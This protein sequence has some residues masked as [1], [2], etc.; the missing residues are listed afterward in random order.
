MK[1]YLVLTYIF[2]YSLTSQAQD[3]FPALPIDSTEV[4]K[5]I[6]HL[7]FAQA[8]TLLKKE[9]TFA[10]RQKKST[11]NLEQQQKN[12]TFAK[13]ALRNTDK[14]VI[15]DSVVVPKSEL[16]SAYLFSPEVGS[17]EMENGGKTTSYTTERKNRTIKVGL[18]PDSILTLQMLYNDV[19]NSNAARPQN[20]KGLNISGDV[21]YPFLMMDGI[22]LY[23]A[24]IN[25]EG[26][27]NYDLYVTR[28][29]SET[30]TF[31]PAEN[32]GFPY[33]SYA[34]DYLLV[35]DEINNIGWF[36]SDRYQPSGYVCIYTFI[37]NASRHPVD[38]ENTAPAT[39]HQWATLLPIRSTWTAENEAQRI[40][41]R[42]HLSLQSV[43]NSQAKKREFELVI[44]DIY[45]YTNLSDFRNP[46]AKEL[47][48]EWI[49]K[50]K[51]FD[52]LSYQ[53]ET[54]RTTFANSNRT[55]QNNMRQQ[56][57][58]LEK[59]VEQINLEIS[60]AEKKIRAAE[61]Q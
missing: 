26:L 13:T 36:A 37:P 34:N 1:N 52:T 47:C 51:N 5:C 8:E 17:I 9:I 44:N 12:C 7:N 16:L 11:A 28:F 35:I 29:N 27:G 22:T 30:N 60:Q 56:I 54:L 46:Q 43:N 38:F 19:E 41:A 50:K 39:I 31:Y 24:G 18:S 15:V 42:Q 58:D 61:L 6:S 3:V 2:L 21:N 25:N 10:K 20:L 4:G 57:L 53:L 59:R 49:Q 40:S 32:L 45:T 55:K 14:L 48:K 23:F 33:N